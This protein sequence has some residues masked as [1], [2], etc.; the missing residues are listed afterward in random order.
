MDIEIFS[1]AAVV[2][3]G[4]PN[5]KDYIYKHRDQLLEE[6]RQKEFGSGN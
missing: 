4:L 6:I 3:T 2:I 5:L 1:Q